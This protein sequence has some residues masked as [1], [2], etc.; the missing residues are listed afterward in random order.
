VDK[1]LSILIEEK[2]E[3]AIERKQLLVILNMLSDKLGK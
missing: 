3:L 2:K 1:L